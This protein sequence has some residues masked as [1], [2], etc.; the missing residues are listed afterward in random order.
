VPLFILTSNRTFS[1]AEDFSYNLQARNRAKVIGETTGGGA[2]PVKFERMANGFVFVVPYARSINPITQTNWEG[3]GV[4]PDIKVTAEMA[5]EKAKEV[6]KIS[7]TQYRETPFKQLETLLTQD[8][9]TANHEETIYQL[10]KLLLA[11]H[12]LETFMV[13]NIGYRYKAAG[14]LA[15]AKAIFKVNIQLFP[16]LPNGYDSYAEVLLENNEYTKA[17]NAYKKAV[18]LAIEQQDSELDMYQSNLAKFEAKLSQ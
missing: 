16:E 18:S 1:A 6:A 8:N 13:N 14:Y 17:H 5:L 7:A 10:F 4:I 3:V 11:R 12:H 9:F 15:A 2:H